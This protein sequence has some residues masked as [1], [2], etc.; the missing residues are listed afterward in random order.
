MSDDPTFIYRVA[1]GLTVFATLGVRDL[2]KNPQ[3]PSRLKEYLF[4]FS[5]TAAVMSYGL[6][7]DLLTFSISPSYF[8]AVKGLPR[9]RFF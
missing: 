5:V 2:L 4:L 1:F 7:H 6:A 3:N 8:S 9:G